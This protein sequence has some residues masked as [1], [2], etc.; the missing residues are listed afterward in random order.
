MQPVRLGDMR[1]VG[2]L[3]GQDTTLSL[4][5]DLTTRSDDPLRLI[6]SG[7]RLQVGSREFDIS[8]NYQAGAPPTVDLLV[9][10]AELD[11]ASAAGTLARRLN[12]DAA[13]L[14]AAAAQR[15]DLRSQLQFDRLRFGAL[16]LLMPG[17][18]SDRKWWFDGQSFSGLPGGHG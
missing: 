11:G 4:S 16:C 9:S 10:G 7:G 12:L 1:L 15:I 13:G 5:G 3:P 8:F 17:W 6:L 14:L 2:Q 18:T